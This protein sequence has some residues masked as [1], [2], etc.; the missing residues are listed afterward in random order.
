MDTNNERKEKEKPE[1]RSERERNRREV[2]K[3]ICELC[4][5]LCSRLVKKETYRIYDTRY[6]YV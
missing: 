5:F 6:Y 1:A 2:D 3:Y 4:I